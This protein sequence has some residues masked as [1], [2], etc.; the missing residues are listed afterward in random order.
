M[1]GERSDTEQ[2]NGQRIDDAKRELEMA[3]RNAIK[4]GFSAASVRVAVHR[5][6]AGQIL[7]QYELS[8]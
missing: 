1:D 3:V 8:R 4:L 6:R 5:G 2:S 7:T